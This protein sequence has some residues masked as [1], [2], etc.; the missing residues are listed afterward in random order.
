MKRTII[1]I[2][3]IAAILLGCSGKKTGSTAK[4]KSMSFDSVVVDT[5]LHLTNDTTSPCME[6]HLS[7]QYAKGENAKTV[8]DS[9]LASGIMMP[10]FLPTAKNTMTIPQVVDSFVKKAL[11]DY[12]DFNLPL[13]RQDPEYSTSLNN[14]FYA[15]TETRSANDSIVNY[16]AH[17][18]YYGGG[19]HGIGQTVVKNINVKNGKIVGLNDIFVPGYEK[20]IV[21]KLTEK[22]VKYFKA[23]DEE[24]LKNYIFLESALYV[25]DNFILGKDKITFI[26]CE[27]EIA[28]HAAGQIDI[29]FDKADLTDIL[30]K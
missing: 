12:K 27:D 11:K 13:Y 2:M 21:S 26:Y 10:D 5:V 6:I 4:V 14:S 18:Y 17:L 7:L 19:A 30:K 22:L 8:N 20:T 1:P 23:K 15:K 25:P 24:D 16:I 29:D 28:A 3:V 9:L